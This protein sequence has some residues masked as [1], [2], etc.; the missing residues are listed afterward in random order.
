M[1]IKYLKHLSV[2]KDVF[3]YV[4][5]KVQFVIMS[6]VKLRIVLLIIFKSSDLIKHIYLN[7]LT[8]ILKH[9]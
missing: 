6:I 8:N 2:L 5:K 9:M 4:F 3:C 1:F 7:V